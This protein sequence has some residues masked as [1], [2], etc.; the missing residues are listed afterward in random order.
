ML[1][2]LVLLAGGCV[3]L[4]FGAE[5]VVRGAA[6]IATVLGFSKAVVGL[7]LVA[8]GTSAPEMFV[9]VLAGYRGE[10]GFALS[11]VSGS[12]LT[13]ICIGFGV[14]GLLGGLPIAW[15]TFRTDCAMLIVS[16]ALVIAVLLLDSSQPHLPAWSTLPFLLLG[17]IYLFTLR[18]RIRDGQDELRPE[19]SSAAWVLLSA[20]VFLAGIAALYGG[21]RLVLDSAVGIAEQLQIPAALIGL[22]VVAAGT[23]VPDTVASVIAARRG[24][25]EIAVGNLLGSNISNVLVV[26]TATIFASLAGGVSP[27][28][29][30][31]G[32]AGPGVLVASQNIVMDYFMVCLVSIL[33]ML[34]ALGARRINQGL[35]SLLLVVYFGYMG[36]RVFIEWPS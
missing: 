24:E 34:L 31:A 35:G 18:R 7:T 8:L 23:S 28:D 9:N 22:T 26:L 32:L 14:C 30:D 1:W 15:R 36:Y 33:F 29:G 11:N 12:N 4:Y 19:E 5:W 3:L 16:V 17:A 2:N 6:R 13:N 25:Y 21:G 27:A 10:T 20:G